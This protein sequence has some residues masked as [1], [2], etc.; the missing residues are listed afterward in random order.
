MNCGVNWSLDEDR[1]VLHQDKVVQLHEVDGSPGVPF[2]TK[3]VS[4]VPV[5][6]LSCMHYGERGLVWGSSAG[7]VN[8]VS[9][10]RDQDKVEEVPICPSSSSNQISTTSVHWNPVQKSQVAAGFDLHKDFCVLIWDV[11]YASGNKMNLGKGPSSAANLASVNRLCYEDGISSLCWMPEASPFVLIVGTSTGW[12]RVFDTRIGSSGAETSFMAHTTARQMRGVA[13]LRP[14]TFSSHSVASFSQTV[15]ESVKIWDLRKGSATKSKMVLAHSVNPQLLEEADAVASG[16]VSSNDGSESNLEGPTAAVVSD[17]IVDVAWSQCR[18]DV[19]AVATTHQVQLYRTMA[20][21]TDADMQTNTAFA[22]PYISTR[23]ICSMSWKPHSNRVLV[24]SP[25]LVRHLRIIDTAALGFNDSVALS[26]SGPDLYTFQEPTSAPDN[27]MA[28]A[29]QESVETLMRERSIA[30]YSFDAGKNLQVLS[31]ELDTLYFDNISGGNDDLN[32]SGGDEGARDETSDDNTATANNKSEAGVG[33]LAQQQIPHSKETLLQLSRVWGWIDRVESLRDEDLTLT[34]CGVLPMFQ[35]HSSTIAAE[36]SRGDSAAATTVSADHNSEEAISS[37]QLT[38]SQ[39]QRME[40]HPVFNIP[41]Y[42]SDYRNSTR[43]VCGWSNAWT[44]PSPR[45]SSGSVRKNNHTLE[46]GDDEEYLDMGVE[47]AVEECEDLDSFERAAALAVWHGHLELGVNVLNRNLASG[48]NYSHHNHNNHHNYHHYQGQSE[49]D[50][51]DHV[52]LSPEYT[53]LVSMVAMCFAGFPN[54]IGGGNSSGTSKYGGHESVW[55]KM[56]T[57]L[58][59]KLQSQPRR[60]AMY[61]AAICRFL[62][63]VL[64]MQESATPG[65]NTKSSSPRRLA[66]SFEYITQDAHLY[67]EDRVAFATFFCQM[68]RWCHGLRALPKFVYPQG[69]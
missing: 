26:A 11:E 6:G 59:I 22:I 34:T 17:R 39:S 13:G 14:A 28:V 42:A 46:T 37:P 50:H 15:G 30:G 49:H 31:E 5:L 36:S 29:C 9:W 43:L 68:K 3:L 20:G 53:Q 69:D 52:R 16:T 4:K 2:T 48:N 32:A 64:Q 45:S 33:V 7:A 25:G 63:H 62:L 57:D 56:C 1:F 18:S 27:G 40:Q 19:L 23:Q 47:A 10:P 66:D 21:T 38:T 54:G 35:T 24:S 44:P 41:T 60:P 58:L 67:L 65:G 8:L 61:L 12:L 55:A 51:H